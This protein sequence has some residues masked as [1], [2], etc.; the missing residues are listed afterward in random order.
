M[1]DTA[2]AKTRPLRLI[3][4]LAAVA[5]VLLAGLAWLNRKA[6][7]REALTGWL[8][9]RGVAAEAE[10]EAF[11][12]S[13]FTARL[14]IG[15]PNNPDFAA[16]RAEVRYRAR[17]TGLEVVSLTLKKP[18]LR[19]AVRKGRLS[20]GALDPL[21]DEFLR[22]P[23]RPSAAKPRV[24]IDGGVLVLATDYGPLRLGADALVDDGKLM[25]LAAA[26]A[27]ARLR[28]S[29]F[30]LALGPATLQAVTHADRVDL[31]L[32]APIESLRVG[33][34]A[35]RD[36][37]LTLVAQGPY[38]DLEKRRGD[39]AVTAN[40]RFASRR[41]ESAGQVLDDAE[42]S[43]A[44]AGQA[45]GWI[46]DLAVSGKGAAS[47]RAGAGRIGAAQA[48][49]LRVAATSEDLRWSRKGGDQVAGTFRLNGAL[50]HLRSGDLTL[51]SLTAAA[52]GPLSASRAGVDATLSGSAVG[53]GGWAGLGARAAGDA[54]QM[55][56]LK[57]AA[58]S[59]AIAAP[60]AAVRLKDG[61]MTVDLGRP[62]RLVPDSGGAVEL[63][64]RPRTPL[65]GPQGGAFRLTAAGGG[66]PQLDAD[67]DRFA[68]IDGGAD[69]VGR[70]RTK[71][72]IGLVQGGEADAAGRLR[73]VDGGLTF[74][75][76][77][78]ATLAAARL[79]FGQND[80]ERL[81][82]RLCPAAGPLLQVRGGGWRLAGRA[83]GVAA[84]APFLQA[85]VEA[86][87]GSVTASGAGARLTAQGRVETARVEDAAPQTRFNPLIMTGRAD[88]AGDTWRADLAFRP[89]GGATLAQARLTHDV[90][91]G[92]GGVEIA[93]GS[94]R[95]AE[96]G[97]QPI[98]LSPLAAAVGS[99]ATGEAQFQGRFDWTPQGVTSGGTLTIPRLDFQSPV[100]RA[101]GLKGRIVFAS[102][103]PLTAAPG[104]ALDADQ[105]QAVVPLTHLKASFALA[106]NLLTIQAG[107]AQV[108]G[109]RVQV[110]S[111]EVPLT[112]GAA[113]RGVLLFEGVQL[114]DVVE[115][116]PFGDKVELDAKVTGRIPFEANGAR[117]RITS[118]ELK[119]IQPGRLS[120]QRTAIS[121]VQAEGAI[122][123]PGA[124]APVAP[125]DTFT[126]FAY[127]AM[128]NLAF[129]TLEATVA[130]REDG[131]LG[132]LF[133][134]VGRHDPPQKQR[135]K[136]SLMDLIQKRFL[137]R[138]LPLPSGTGVNLTLDTTL[139]LDDLLADFAEYRRL[140]GSGPVQP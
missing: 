37:R 1:T 3:L 15:D 58:R 18:V 2:T 72:S 21:V 105:V 68:L 122:T 50:E 85:R 100:G 114:H 94:L 99:P 74:T 28:G 17:L 65:F 71:A 59:F 101:E 57:R 125:N 97:L 133:H 60:S 63:T 80:V 79:E 106:G 20:V 82:G 88:L 43:A 70:I 123:A 108:G 140:H 6:L 136:L 139:N 12:P 55:A 102:L 116:S 90:R 33:A 27:P 62:V 103:A 64:P 130:S 22:R 134:I 5:L 25:R 117:V 52:S 47:L 77:R 38:P 4:A 111:L 81:S 44:L 87:A 45:S 53:R 118:G 23:P 75:A 126:D 69:A 42:L 13:V 48:R 73:L 40:L 109:G 66:L 84:A 61:A 39:G 51:S 76:T 121:G 16:E 110:E 54:P 7:A 49:T 56:A 29:G 34:A 30:E 31:T 46:P 104:Q 11:G 26:S 115:A 67:V 35:A 86:G 19:A 8:K 93:T 36:G 129:D 91:R 131:R 95:F 96:G 132:V 113:T 32:A 128:E 135:I 120:I 107:E 24:E 124:A 137:G 89:P 92:V 119:A 41:L 9:S 83:E 78:C 138:T 10:V 112:P 98:Q 14:R 127:Q